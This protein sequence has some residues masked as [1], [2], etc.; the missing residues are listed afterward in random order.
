MA[1][2]DSPWPGFVL[3]RGVALLL[4]LL[5]IWI[6]RPAWA[7]PLA[8]WSLVDPEGQRLTAVVFEQPDPADPPGLRLRLNA[9]SPGL[10]LDHR[11]PL[12]WRDGQG[13]I[14][15][16]INRSAELVPP[17]ATLLPDGSAQFDLAAVRPLPDPH[18]PLRLTVPTAGGDRPFASATSP[19]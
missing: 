19:A 10:R 3:R 16:L 17:G 9:R 2:S 8:R 14:H 18:Q 4:L 12:L 7:A 15:V 1:S 5:L 13:E 11:R 6:G